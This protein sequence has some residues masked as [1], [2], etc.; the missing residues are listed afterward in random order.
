MLDVIKGRVEH[1][2][3]PT[4]ISKHEAAISKYETVASKGQKI[5][6]VSLYIVKA[7]FIRYGGKIIFI[8]L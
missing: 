3:V 6:P 2:Q 7:L 4:S 1:S 8:C 5:F